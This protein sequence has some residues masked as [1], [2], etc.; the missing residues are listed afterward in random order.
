[1]PA[2]RVSH[3]QELSLATRR[4]SYLWLIKRLANLPNLLS[5]SEKQTKTTI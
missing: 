3:L 1:M 5:R 2:T 4:R